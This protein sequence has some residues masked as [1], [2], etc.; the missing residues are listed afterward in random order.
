MYKEDDDLKLN[1]V[2]SLVVQPSV[3]LSSPS[4]KTEVKFTEFLD[5]YLFTS[6]IL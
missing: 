2:L 1:V 4:R 6:D 5:K 3:E